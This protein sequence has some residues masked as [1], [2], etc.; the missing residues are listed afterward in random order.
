MLSTTTRGAALVALA[1]L[2]LTTGGQAQA[3][4]PLG[5]QFWIGGGYHRSITSPDNGIEVRPGADLKIG[6]L[7][8]GVSGRF[9][10][11]K[12]ADGNGLLRSAWSF[13]VTLFLPIPVVVPYFRIG[14]GMSWLIDQI[15]GADPLRLGLHQGVGVD[16][17][18]P[19]HLAIGVLF[20][21]DESLDRR[22]WSADVG[23]T[24]LIVVKLRV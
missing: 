17:L 3:K 22:D 4:G 24:W 2:C 21:V 12:I 8:L 9:N 15:G 13:D 5:A 14:V 16:I 23:T 11:D 7:G 10:S 20:D 1:L 6:P 19:K 18:I